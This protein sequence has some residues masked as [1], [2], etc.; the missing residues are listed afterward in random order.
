MK[1]AIATKKVKPK[2]IAT[3]KNRP[4]IRKKPGVRYPIVKA[5]TKKRG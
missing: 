3:K 1:K 5:S 2:A 4:I